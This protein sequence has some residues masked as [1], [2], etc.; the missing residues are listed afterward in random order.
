MPAEPGL[1][2]LRDAYEE[3]DRVLREARG[4]FEATRTAYADRRRYAP[5][6]AQTDRARQAMGLAGMDWLRALIERETARDR[7]DSERRDQDADPFGGLDAG[8][9]GRR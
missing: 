2:G 9:G 7:L 6:G 1:S 5:S 4:V 3:A 8:P